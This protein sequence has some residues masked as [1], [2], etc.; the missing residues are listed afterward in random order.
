MRFILKSISMKCFK[1]FNTEVIFEFDAKGNRIYGENGIGKSTIADAFLWVFANRSYELMDN[2]PVKSNEADDADLVC[3]TI[4][5]EADGK[6]V[7]VVKSQ[8][9]KVG[10]NR[11]G[12]ETIALTNS[13]EINAVEYSARDFVKKLNEYGIDMERFLQFSHPDM[14]ISGMGDKKSRD[15]M[16][17]TLFAMGSLYTDLKIAQM[18]DETADVA[19]LLENYT[20]EEVEKMQKSTMRKINENYGL[21]GEILDAEI[22]GMSES[23]SD[24]DV[25]ALE[26][27]KEELTEKIAELEKQIASGAVDTSDLQKRLNKVN[28]DISDIQG[29]WQKENHKQRLG[30]QDQMSEKEALIQGLSLDKKHKEKIISHNKSEMKSIGEELKSLSGK[31]EEVKAKTF[32][33]SKWVFDENTTI[34]SLCGQKLPDDRIEELKTEFTEKKE[35]AERDFKEEKDTEIERIKSKG[36]FATSEYK[37]LDQENRQIADSIE[38]LDEES[39]GLEREVKAIHEQIGQIPS[40]FDG[41]DNEKYQKLLAEKDKIETEMV[42]VTASEADTSE[43]EVERFTLKAE[44]ESVMA[45]L[46]KAGANADIDK[47][48]AEKYKQKA[49]YEQQKADCEKILYQLSLVSMKKNEMLEESV[50]SHFKLVKWQLFERQ[51][52]GE[53][54]DACIPFI[55]GFRFGTSTNTGREIL[56]KLDI[57]AGLQDFF[58]Q[59][60]PIFL[61]GAEA[62]SEVTLD[63]IDIDSQLI[64]LNVSEDTELRFE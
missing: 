31:L 11:H 33:E 6:P 22:R 7:T 35:D 4:E 20:F 55:D 26:S 64:M 14:F 49:E 32:D 57:I 15:A 21:H 51:K 41:T 37:R 63:R 9:M 17:N 28:A 16:R 54:K 60:Y 47:A 25:S 40:V 24:T 2:P 8:K 42:K 5:G 30:L 34:C 58:D 38:K 53:V 36:E 12:A 13:Y 44:L 46:G 56:A 59:H 19:K 52:N 62:L 23:K 43:I 10:E 48:I 39:A 61:D 3:V 45:D 29:E 18:G 50:N 1:K 27:K